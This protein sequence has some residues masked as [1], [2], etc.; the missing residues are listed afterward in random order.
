MK[1]LCVW[2][3]LAAATISLTAQTTDE[4][5]LLTIDGEP[6]TVSEFMYIY[7]KNNQEAQIDQKSI[8]EYLELFINFKLKVKAAEEQ[9]IDT[10]AAFLKELAGYRS[11]STPKYMVDPVSEEAV[12]QEVYG[13]MLNDRR[14]SHIAI[15][16]P[17][18]A[19]QDE[20]IEARRKIELAH[21]R[22]TTGIEKTVRKNKKVMTPVE[23]FNTV[24]VEMSDDPQAAQNQGRI[25]WVRPFRFVFPFEDAAYNTKV[26]EVSGIFRTPFGFHI[27][28]V[29]EEIPHRE[30][31]ASHIMKMTPGNDEEVAAKAKTAIDSIY[32]LAKAGEDFA[33]LAIAN[34]D[35]RGSAQRGGDLGWFGRGQMVPEFENAAFALAME[36]EIAE[37]VKSNYGWHIIKFHDARGTADLADIREEVMKNIRRSDYQKLINEGF[38]NKLKAEYDFA[39]NK[40]AMAPFYALIA[41][42]AVG[43]SAFVAAAQGLQD[44]M[45]TFA[46]QERTQAD[47][48]GYIQTNGFSQQQTQKGILEEKYAYFVEKELRA[49]EDSQLENKYP[50]LKNLITEYHDGILLFEVSLREVWEKAGS[51]TAG[52]TAYFNEHKKEYTWDAPRYKGYLIRAKDKASMKA[53][54]QIVRNAD[55]DSVISYVNKRINVDSVQYVIVEK[56]L[57]KQGDRPAVDKYAF[58]AGDYQPT[59]EYPLVTVAGKKLKAPEEYTDERGKVTSAYQD[60]LEKEWIAR[61]RKEHKV[62]VNK[63]VLESLKQ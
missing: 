35:D 23:D 18:N 59:E 16:C 63:E 10:T 24:A 17:M 39:E 19:T 27:L 8:D 62:E 52:I 60:Y 50:E 29:E 21:A 55:P 36:G 49:Y 61:L 32:A 34:S 1:R 30:I 15:R 57:W 11:Q 43:D 3:A 31:H 58:K 9:G 20:E 54:K 4:R 46:G 37:P 48:L 6:S 5:V 7:Q 13:R 38:L 47:F 14:V 41:E 28:K 56:G 33:A 25:G 51:D 44:V 40:E 26:G 53:A 2:V 45:F 12:V 22:V 42:H